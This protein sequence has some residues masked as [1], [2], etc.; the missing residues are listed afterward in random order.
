[1]KE[2]ETGREEVKRDTARVTEKRKKEASPGLK[3][4]RRQ[5]EEREERTAG[6][7]AVYRYFHLRVEEKSKSRASGKLG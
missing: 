7:F 3:H 4:T 6:A 5:R 1:M 2:R